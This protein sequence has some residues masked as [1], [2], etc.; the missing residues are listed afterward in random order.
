MSEPNAVEQKAHE[1]LMVL[2]GVSLAW[3]VAALDIARREIESFSSVVKPRSPEAIHHDEA[4]REA[5]ARDQAEAVSDGFVR[6]IRER[7][8]ELDG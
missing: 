2:D 8:L 3:A 1:I 5:D 7:V 6:L 4:A